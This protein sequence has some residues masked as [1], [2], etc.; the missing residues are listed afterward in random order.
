MT[1]LKDISVFERSALD[2]FQNLSFTETNTA[3]PVNI[4]KVLGVVAITD[5]G[6]SVFGDGLHCG[7]YPS[8]G[9]PFLALEVILDAGWTYSSD[10]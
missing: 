2:E 5:F 9:E 7:P 3:S 6:F 1:R 8:I 4:A 10:I